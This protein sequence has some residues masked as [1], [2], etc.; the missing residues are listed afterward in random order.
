[1][2][3][4]YPQFTQIQ[5]GNMKLYI[6]LLTRTHKQNSLT[7]KFCHITCIVRAMANEEAPRENNS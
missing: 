1:M 7:W 4:L 3:H 6:T 2:F 5:Q